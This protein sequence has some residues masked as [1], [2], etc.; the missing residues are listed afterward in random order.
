MT[1]VPTGRSPEQPGS[2]PDDLADELV[3][4]DDVAVLVPYEQPGAVVGVGMVHV[5]DVRR[6]DR[7]ADRPDQQ[8]A[9]PWHR[10]RRLPHLEAT[11]TQYHRSHIAPLRRRQ[12]AT[13]IAQC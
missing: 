13:V 1:R 12:R 4:H 7:G 5:V 3:T 2:Q 9:F 11:P 10:I 6:T 8:L